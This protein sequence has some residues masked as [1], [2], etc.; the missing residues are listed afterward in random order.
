MAPDLKRYTSEMFL[1]YSMKLSG[2]L[3]LT[4]DSVAFLESKQAAPSKKQQQSVGC[5]KTSK[6]A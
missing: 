5:S 3:S 6:Q 4:D 1:L 2:C